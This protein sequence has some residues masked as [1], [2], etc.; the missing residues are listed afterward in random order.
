MKGLQNSMIRLLNTSCQLVYVDIRYI[1]WR[2]GK[3]KTNKMLLRTYKNGRNFVF[4]KKLIKKFFINLVIR[5]KINSI[6]QI[7]HVK[8][9]QIMIKTI[10]K[11]SDI[12][13]L[14]NSS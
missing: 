1:Q 8:L 9:Y 7:N 6:R 10:N 11:Y 14:I 13:W 2:Q 4:M 12:F 3:R 5:L